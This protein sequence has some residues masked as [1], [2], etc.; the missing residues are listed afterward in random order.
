M[1]ID[2]AKKFA[3]E[4]L[5]AMKNETLL[6]PAQQKIVQARKLLDEAAEISE[7]HGIPIVFEF[8]GIEFPYIPK[9]FSEIRT[10][11]AAA[12]EF[13]L[14]DAMYD[15]SPRMPYDQTEGWAEFW[16]SSSLYC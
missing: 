5:S 2:E 16:S 6:H 14:V 13:D 8:G 9:K 7:E 1:K 3:E 15:Y 10:A 4:F 12:A 11:L